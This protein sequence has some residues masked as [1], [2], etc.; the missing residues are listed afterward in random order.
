MFFPEVHKGDKYTPSA[1][2]ENA[3]NRRL[4]SINGFSE[5]PITKQS[6]STE[7]SSCS[8]GIDISV[9]DVEDDETAYWEVTII[10][11][12][13][14]TRTEVVNVRSSCFRVAK[15]DSST[16]ERYCSVALFPAMRDIDTTTPVYSVD[17]YDMGCFIDNYDRTANSWSSWSSSYAHY[18]TSTYTS[19]YDVLFLDRIVAQ[20]ALIDL[21]TG[22]I[23]SKLPSSFLFDLRYY[24]DFAFYNNLLQNGETT[25]YQS[26]GLVTFGSLTTWIEGVYA[27]PSGQ[28]VVVSYTSSNNS[29][30]G[31]LSYS[32]YTSSALIQVIDLNA[33]HEYP[34]GL[35]ITGRVSQ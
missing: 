4:N 14:A 7:V 32:S 6:S 35:Y 30:T 22:E 28:Q 27:I 20:L 8:C 9:E 21:S 26:G 3:I 1:Q 33:N 19:Q 34:N 18:P 17:G 15:V 12:F 13:V 23:I 11:L 16:S 31:Y 24:G 10:G 5:V 29:I 2:R 25:R